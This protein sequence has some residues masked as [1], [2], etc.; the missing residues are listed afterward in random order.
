MKGKVVIITGAS[1]GIGKACA[2][3]FGMAGAGVVIAARNKGNLNTVSAALRGRGVAVLAVQ[4]D[5]SREED[6]RMLV[7][8][9]IA[10]F[11]K[12]D[13]LI[14]NAGISMRALFGSVQL[15]VLKRLMDV[16]FWGTV[17]CTRYALPY[18][19][20][21]K[22]SL[23]GMSSVAGKKGLPGRAGYSASKFAME[24]FLETIRIENMKAGLHV[25][26]VCPGFTASN[27]RNAALSGDGV[28][29][30]ESPLDESSVMQPEEVARMTLQGVRNRR[31]N[32]ILSLKGKMIVFL[33]KF[34][35]AFS[36][37]LVYN[38][39]LKEKDSPLK[40]G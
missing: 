17:Y 35:P 37:R 14:N 19:L 25:M 28:P 8:K 38:H 33:S 5:V 27:I 16:N 18:L 34:F 23:V 32:M 20:E 31:R 11:G 7:Q 29:Q 39:F 26:V 24:G 3:A 2:E 22:G 1:S 6:C 30:G 9:T 12:V 13:V 40:K 15:D 4:A 10:E 21:A 36:D